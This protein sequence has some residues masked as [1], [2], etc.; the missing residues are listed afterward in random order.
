MAKTISVTT[1]LTQKQVKAIDSLIG[2]GK[3]ISRSEALRAIAKE[4]LEKNSLL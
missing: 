2:D 1:R 3:F 4:Y